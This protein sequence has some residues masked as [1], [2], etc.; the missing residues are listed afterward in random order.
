MALFHFVLSAASQMLVCLVLSRCAYGLVT[1]VDD[2]AIL[3]VV[4]LNLV[5][6]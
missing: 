4:F 3:V 6:R 1:F 5:S 2:D